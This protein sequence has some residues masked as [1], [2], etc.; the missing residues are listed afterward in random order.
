MKKTTYT[1]AILATAL[2]SDCAFTEMDNAGDVLHINCT[3]S[4]SSGT[5]YAVVHSEPQGTESDVLCGREM[6]G[7]P[8]FNPYDRVRDDRLDPLV[9][10]PRNSVWYCFFSTM[11]P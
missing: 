3:V 7:S 11:S 8:T 4:A 9:G 2:F 1:A 5:P 6:I 10:C